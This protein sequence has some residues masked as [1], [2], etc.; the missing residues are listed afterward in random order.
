MYGLLD[1]HN[2]IYDV[3]NINI[4]NS[5]DFDIDPNEFT[6]SYNVNNIFSY[7]GATYRGPVFSPKYFEFRYVEL[8]IDCIF[9]YY[10]RNI[11][12][13]LPNNI[14]FD[15]NIFMV[16]CLLSKNLKMTPELAWYI[17]TEDDF[18][19]NIKNKRN[20]SNLIKMIDNPNIQCFKTDNITDYQ[21]FYNMSCSE[22]V[23]FFPF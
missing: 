3:Q 11:E 2:H 15:E 9:T 20:K 14:Y 22:M 19:V 18:I 21:D 10:K 5:I 6:T 1:K 12:F 23:R 16:Y 13:R 7:L 4:D 17:K 8:L